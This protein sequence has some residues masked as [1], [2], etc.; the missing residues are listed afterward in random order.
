MEVK[1][2]NLKITTSILNQTENINP[3]FV[4]E[5]KVLGWC[6]HKEMKFIVL[7]DKES[8]TLKKIKYYT[9]VESSD[10]LSIQLNRTNKDE[11]EVFYT[12]SL[13]ENSKEMI[14]LENVRIEAEEK[15]QF[16]I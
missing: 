14:T 2:K 11:T 3:F 5:L 8:S 9:S 6:L 10:G 4:S 13:E 12:S 15:G 16:Y 1:I 7:Y